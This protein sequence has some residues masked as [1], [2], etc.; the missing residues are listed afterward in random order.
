[1]IRI[2]V[3]SDPHCGH[4]LGLTPPDWWQKKTLSLSKPVWEWR[5]GEL[6]K[7]GPVDIHIVLGDLTDGPGIKETLGLLTTDV[8]EQAEM[9]AV[10]LGIVRAKHRYLCYG[11]PLHTVSTLSHE[12]LVATALGCE[13]HETWRL[14]LGGVRFNFRHVVGRSDVPYG[15]GTQVAKEIVRDELQALAESYEPADVFGRG[16][17][18]YWYRVDTPSKTA[19]IC[20]TLELPNPDK[21]GNIYTRKLRTMY[22]DVG[23]VLIEIDKTG[24]VFIRPRLMPM[25]LAIRKEYTCPLEVKRK[26]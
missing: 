21:D 2:L 24:E 16:H 6:R 13:I 14:K 3:E 25:K 5:A 7:I 18:H 11:T 1:V 17:A 4:I 9:A 12:N 15:Q 10:G 19:F 22:Y 26:G 23:F 20:P 8:E